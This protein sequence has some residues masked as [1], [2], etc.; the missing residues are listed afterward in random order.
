M[1]R[2]QNCQKIELYGSPITKELKKKHSFR[3][4]GGVETG[5][6]SRDGQPVWRGRA[7]RWWQEDW[8]GETVAGRLDVPTFGF[9]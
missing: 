9:R 5:S 4:V 2:N 8:V 1:K 7:A 3:M 6:Q